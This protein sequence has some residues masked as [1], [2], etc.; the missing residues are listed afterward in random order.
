MVHSLAQEKK[1]AKGI[2]MKFLIVAGLVFFAMLAVLSAYTG[3]EPQMRMFISV[4]AGILVGG[5][6]LK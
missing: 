5:W 4:I 1:Q 6:L 2:H 3:V